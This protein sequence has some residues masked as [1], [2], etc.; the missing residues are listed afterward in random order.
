MTFSVTQIDAPCG[1]IV[2]GLDLT[3]QLDDLTGCGAQAGV[4]AQPCSDL[5]K[6]GAFR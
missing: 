3:K 5:S 4:V 2:E 1:A 6:P